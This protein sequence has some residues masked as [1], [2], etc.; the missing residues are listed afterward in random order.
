MREHNAALDQQVADL[1][2]ERDVLLSLLEDN[3]TAW[4]GEEDSVREEHEA[5]IEETREA[6][7]GNRKA[8]PRLAKQ[9][10]ILRGAL[11]DI[12]SYAEP[13]AIDDQRELREAINASRAALEA[14]KEGA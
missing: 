7:D 11:E 8:V 3:L 6:V 1:Q 13:W 5:L 2:N 4:D 12:I 14:T 9:V 10:R